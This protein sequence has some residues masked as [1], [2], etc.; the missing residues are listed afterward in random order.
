MTEKRKN[1]NAGR[2]DYENALMPGIMLGFGGMLAIL[3]YML[4]LLAGLFSNWLFGV[5]AL[6]FSHLVF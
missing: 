4:G 5:L 2:Q 3:F 1:P 6:I